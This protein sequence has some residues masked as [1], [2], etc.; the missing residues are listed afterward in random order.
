M[1]ARIFSRPEKLLY[2]IVFEPIAIK[3]IMLHSI[4]FSNPMKSRW[5]WK[6]VIGLLGGKLD[7]NGQV[8]V[9]DSFPIT[10]GSKY[11]VQFHNKN[12][13]LASIINDNLSERNEFFVGWYH[14]HPG[15]G[16]FYSETDI[17]NHLGY[18]DVNPKAIGLVFDHE[19][20]NKHGHFFEV[21]NLDYSKYGVSGYHEVPYSIKGISKK[22]E[23]SEL[24]RMFD[25]ILFYWKINFVESAEKSLKKW[26]KT[27][28]KS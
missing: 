22:R 28:K 2:K 27:Q 3:K 26:L 24:K 6:E 11:H 10:H 23:H 1:S 13:I 5:R 21:Y 7:K 17:I 16:F 19:G 15:L 8:I 25:R 18:Q 4:E 14:S 9:T 12:Y 20:Y